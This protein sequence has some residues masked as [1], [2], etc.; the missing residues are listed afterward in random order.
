[1]S[2]V[3]GSGRSPQATAAKAWSSCGELE[4]MRGSRGASKGPISCHSLQCGTTTQDFGAIV[5]GLERSRG[6]CET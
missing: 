6:V 1:M 2:S 3:S 5:G 4:R